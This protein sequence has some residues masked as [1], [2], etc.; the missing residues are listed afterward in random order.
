MEDREQN[1]QDLT[2]RLRTLKIDRDA[3]TSTRSR[4]LSIIA[5]F[6]AL[7]GCGALVW[8]LQMPSAT[9]PPN[10]TTFETG[11]YNDSR[12]KN[13]ASAQI[14]ANRAQ[15]AT[16]DPA[17]RST[18]GLDQTPSTHWTV[19][20]YLVA[21]RASLVSAEVTANISEVLV[22]EGSVVAQGDI[23]ARL[24]STL[25]RA[26]LQIA[27]ARAAA[28]A[29]TIEAARAE[30]EEAQRVL[31]RAKSLSAR[32]ILSA[33]ELT[34]AQ[35]RLATF[36]ARLGEAEARQ[37]MTAREAERAAAVVAK[38]EISA[39]FA[40]AVTECTGQVG[41]TI[42]PMSSG[43]SIRNGICR[44]VDTKSIEI[45]LDVPETLISRV[46]LGAPADAYL[47]AYPT[48]ALPAVVRAIA[49]SASREKSTIKVRLGFRRLDARLRPNMAVKVDLQVAVLE[50]DQ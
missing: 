15:A 50:K 19:A 9:S 14:A 29:K 10:A 25:P 5:V 40:G 16:I 1:R 28:A 32:K 36:Q 46:R 4:G 39:P 45:E 42:S 47:D 44:I 37:Q 31:Q 8:Q 3:A 18:G 26:D 43:G 21:R 24:D 35:T 30:V 12:P 11:V 27:M 33:A 34:K 41:E 49:P 23:I 7:I 17:P 38:H 6:A 22:E 20:G 48:D 13:A 2:E